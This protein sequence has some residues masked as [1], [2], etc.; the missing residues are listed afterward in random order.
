LLSETY[1]GW[2]RQE[3]KR[4]K[5]STLTL[6]LWKKG[7]L[8]SDLLSSEKNPVKE[9]KETSR[10]GKR[11]AGSIVGKTREKFSVGA[12]A[13]NRDCS[14]LLSMSREG[15]KGAEQKGGGVKRQLATL[16]FIVKGPGA[17]IDGLS[18]EM[19][20]FPGCGGTQ[21]GWREGLASQATFRGVG[22]WTSPKGT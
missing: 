9:K 7:L 16:K 20:G 8:H 3:K 1:E 22:G 6:E 10:E 12:V 13:N 5:V 15:E 2:K 17:R 14:I 4:G 11:V 21:E 18:V 19:N